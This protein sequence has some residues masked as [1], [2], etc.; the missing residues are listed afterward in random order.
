MT[1]KEI[2]EGVGVPVQRGIYTARDRPEQ[3]ITYQRIN[4][5]PIAAA[6]DDVVEEIEMW[7]VNIVSKCDFEGVLKKAKRALKEAGCYVNEIETE[8][9]EEETGYWMVPITIEILKE[10]EL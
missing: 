7:R 9:Y 8:I 1:I 5:Q 4:T 3:Y 2:L 6:D 10:G